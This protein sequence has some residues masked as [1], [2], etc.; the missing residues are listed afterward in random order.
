MPGRTKSRERALQ[1]LYPI[2]VRRI[3]VEDALADFAHSLY[4]TEEFPER[5]MEK[6]RFM[7]ELVHGVVRHQVTL[8]DN[9]TRHAKNWRI[10][11]MSPVDRNILRI[12]AF[13]LSQAELA[14]AVIIDEAVEMARRFSGEE[15]AKFVN[16][17]LD[18]V[19]QSMQAAA[20]SART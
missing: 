16:G 19:R 3:S 9:I 5:K 18:A 14:P 12:A 15:A 2:D 6:D 11:R 8:D 13:E 10:E 4:S 7:E 20:E 1:V 17:I